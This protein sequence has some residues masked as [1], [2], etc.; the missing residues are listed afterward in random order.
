MGQDIVICFPVRTAIASF[1]GSFK[2][3]P[4]AALGAHVIAL[5]LERF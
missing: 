5:C 2:G 3:T 4:A 1:G